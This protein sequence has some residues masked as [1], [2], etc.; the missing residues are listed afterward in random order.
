MCSTYNSGAFLSIS[1]RNHIQHSSVLAVNTCST[2]TTAYT[3]AEN[4]VPSMGRSEILTAVPQPYFWIAFQRW[5]YSTQQQKE[6]RRRIRLTVFEP[7][8][9]QLPENVSFGVGTLHIVELSSLEN[10]FRGWS[11]GILRDVSH[12]C[13]CGETGGSQRCR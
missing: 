4:Q 6:C 7:S 11:R 10:R 3:A 8:H 5:V 13:Y 12:G 2:S 9:Q 1:C